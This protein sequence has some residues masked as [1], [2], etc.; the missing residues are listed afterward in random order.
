MPFVVTGLV[1]GTCLGAGMADAVQDMT[2]RSMEGLK[3]IYV[4]VGLLLGPVAGFVAARKFALSGIRW[5]DIGAAGWWKVGLVCALASSLGAIA[6]LCLGLAWMQ[7][8]PSGDLVWIVFSVMGGLL[9]IFVPMG[10]LARKQRP[11]DEAS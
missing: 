8:V 4:T 11:R 9:G 7:V 3:G 6:G 5:G 2:H 10:W 1:A